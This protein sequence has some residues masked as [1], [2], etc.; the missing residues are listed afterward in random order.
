MQK[1]LRGLEVQDKNLMEHYV[2]LFQKQ[3]RRLAQ[4]SVRY[5]TAEAY[6]ANKSFVDAVVYL[7]F[8]PELPGGDTFAP[9]CQ[10]ALSLQGQQGQ[11]P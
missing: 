10:P 6:F 11:A 9:S 2:S 7:N 1:A 5:V 8:Q 3:C 4:L